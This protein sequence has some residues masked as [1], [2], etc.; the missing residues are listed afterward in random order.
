MVCRG[1]RL[2]SRQ[3]NIVV[4]MLHTLALMIGLT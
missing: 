1:L 4:K 2:L 3:A